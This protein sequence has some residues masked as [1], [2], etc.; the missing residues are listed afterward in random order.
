[1]FPD[2]TFFLPLRIGAA[3]GHHAVLLPY[4]LCAMLGP[5]SSYCSESCAGLVCLPS[6]R[7]VS[8]CLSA[9]SCRPTLDPGHFRLP[10]SLGAIWFFQMPKSKA[11]TPALWPLVHVGASYVV[12]SPALRTVP[13]LPPTQLYGVFCQM[14]GLERK[15]QDLQTQE[16]GLCRITNDN[17]PGCGSAPAASRM[18]NEVI[19]QESTRSQTE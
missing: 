4:T 5:T 1:M 7:I 11:S 14:L 13:G 10:T 2:F 8:A 18:A 16:K 15:S 19:L 3:R 17:T 9:G 6:D 12:R